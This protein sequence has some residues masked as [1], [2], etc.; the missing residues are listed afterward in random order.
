VIPSK[1]C[2]S[3]I[4]YNL[5]ISQIYSLTLKQQLTNNQNHK[6]N[7]MCL[8]KILPPPECFAGVN[9][10]AKGSGIKKNSNKRRLSFAPEISRVVGTVL[11]L[12]EYTA[13]E[14]ETCWWSASDQQECRHNAKAVAS[15]VKKCG[16]SFVALL[17]DSYKAAQDLSFHLSE[18]AVDELLND[19][20]KYTQ[21]LEAWVLIG[22]ERRGLEK[23][24]SMLQRSQRKSGASET[25]G[26][27]LDLEQMGISGDEIGK[28]YAM[29]CRTSRIYA[30][31]MGS[32]DRCSTCFL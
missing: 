23:S 1:E 29:H 17:D 22:K 20:S 7:K 14:I 24:I 5:I 31:M 8:A 21:K 9:G 27:V 11:P 32:A 10:A 16:R 18:T 25:R 19:P 30:R 12:H 13:K 2:S 6:N 28:L 4:V 26:M 15:S 3:F